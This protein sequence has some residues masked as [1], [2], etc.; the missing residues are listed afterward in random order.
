MAFPTA[1][2]DQI[3]DAISQ[4]NLTVLGQS[5]ATAVATTAQSLAHSFGLRLSAEQAGSARLGVLRE[6]VTNKC[7][8]TLGKP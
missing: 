1:V 3:T 8:Q 2:N 6:A 5:S 4:S 7:V